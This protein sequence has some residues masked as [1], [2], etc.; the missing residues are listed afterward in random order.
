M[1]RPA[2]QF[3]LYTFKT[4]QL[5][6]CSCQSI[7]LLYPTILQCHQGV[8][9]R[10]WICTR[11]NT[12]GQTR[13]ESLFAIYSRRTSL[14]M[15]AFVRYVGREL[16]VPVG[17][18]SQVV[19]MLVRDRIKLSTVVDLHYSPHSVCASCK[20]FCF[21]MVTRPMLLTAVIEPSTRP[22]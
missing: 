18:S 13:W 8:S 12:S 1:E 9:R 17:N 22:A 20:L 15:N 10:W 16:K 3:R 19:K 14:G 21:L 7:L 6:L 2:E 4:S 5:W 11:T